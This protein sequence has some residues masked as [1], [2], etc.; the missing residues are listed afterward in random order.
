MSMQIPEQSTGTGEAG[1]LLNL[2]DVELD[3]QALEHLDVRVTNATSG[4]A[5][6]G[7]S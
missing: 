5:A 3:P 6:G 1:E 4:D 7:Q 2:D